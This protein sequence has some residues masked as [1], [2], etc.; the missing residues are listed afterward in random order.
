[1]EDSGRKFWVIPIQWEQWEIILKRIRDDRIPD[2][3]MSQNG[4]WS[5]IL[6]PE[7]EWLR[8]RKLIRDPR[9]QTC[10]SGSTL[11]THC[12]KDW[13]IFFECAKHQNTITRSFLRLRKYEVRW[14]TS[15]FLVVWFF[16]ILINHV[17]ISC[18]FKTSAVGLPGSRAL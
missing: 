14:R 15:Y 2:V 5:M 16:W 6:V 8:V 13:T 10:F 1:M 7:N 12:T 11:W 4:L 3:A 17:S 9:L 18:I